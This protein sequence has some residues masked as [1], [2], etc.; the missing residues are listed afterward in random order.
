MDDPSGKLDSALRSVY[1][2][3][4]AVLE[5]G[6]RNV[7]R[8][9]PLVAHPGPFY[10]YVH[11]KGSLDAIANAGFDS[12]APDREGVALGVMRLES[13]E[14]I[15]SHPAVL[16]LEIG[17]PPSA[18]LDQSIPD[19]RASDVWT[20]VMPGN[21]FT[22]RTGAGVIVGIIDTGIDYRH[23]DF[24]KTGEIH[25]S[26]ILRIWDMGLT[27]KGTEQGPA[28]ALLSGG[29][30]YGVE[31]KQDQIDADLASL[32]ADSDPTV[33]HLDCAG[34]G[35]H[36]TSIATGAGRAREAPSRTGVAPEASIIAVRYLDL[37][38]PTVDQGGVA[39]TPI[40]LFKDAVRYVLNVASQT[41]GGTPVVLNMSF[42]E[43]LGPHDGTSERELWLAGEFAPSQTRRACVHAAGNSNTFTYHVEVDFPAGGGEIHVPFQ[44]ADL[45][46]E[47]KSDWDTCE[48]RDN[49]IELGVE[50]WYV[51]GTANVSAAVTLPD[52][53]AD[54]SHTTKTS[55]FVAIGGGVAGIYFGR[56]EYKLV[57]HT[58][59]DVTVGTT[60]LHRNVIELTLKAE[61]NT[62]AAASNVYELIVRSEAAAHLEGWTGSSNGQHIVFGH[63]VPST[64]DLGTHPPLPSGVTDPRR[65]Q[66]SSPAGAS[67][68]IAVA[69][70]SAEPDPTDLLFSDRPPK[71]GIAGFSSRGGLVDYAS[72]GSLPFKPDLAAPG[73]EV[74]AAR[75]MGRGWLV[76]RSRLIRSAGYTQMGGTSMAAPH[77]TG[78][79]ALMLQAKP[80][81]TVSQISSILTNPANLRPRPSNPDPAKDLELRLTYGAGLLDVKKIMDVVEALP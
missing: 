73:I 7:G 68:T 58:V 56:K 22:G 50:F 70:Y 28:D 47:M 40:K 79:V 48:W 1:D 33:R 39:V 67:N 57:H 4:R 3:Y 21:T 41:D 81:L 8:V 59:P 62:H 14:R 11:Y 13:L 65:H 46:G 69:A 9:L 51:R 55:G 72:A 17:T 32:S 75:S 12:V 5:H 38:E 74:D 24:L 43:S 27:P 15:A 71:H 18:E 19:V 77:V 6:A 78:T 53:S 54:G 60:T 63:F 37:P 2:N 36:V 23:V 49:T 45:R 66:I 42:G 76:Y 34:H 16:R 20:K 25:K 35:T 31:Y 64:I 80:N 30:T 26:R 52:R 10:V 29:A 44:V 61:G